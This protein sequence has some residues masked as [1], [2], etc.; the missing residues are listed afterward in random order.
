M[1]KNS[2]WCYC[3]LIQNK[4]FE[5]DGILCADYCC[6][7]AEFGYLSH[8]IL[9]SI[10]IFNNLLHIFKQFDC[11]AFQLCR[12]YMIPFYISSISLKHVSAITRYTRYVKLNL[13]VKMFLYRVDLDPSFWYHFLHTFPYDSIPH[14]FFPSNLRTNSLGVRYPNAE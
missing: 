6:M 10:V 9:R 2:V 4:L 12:N 7:V 11:G 1:T 8:S 3:T 13:D 14:L 5:L